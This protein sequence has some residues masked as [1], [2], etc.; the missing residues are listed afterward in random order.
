MVSTGE[1][2]CQHFESKSSN[3]TK[4]SGTPSNVV[5]M[6]YLSPGASFSTRTEDMAEFVS[7]LLLLLLLQFITHWHIFQWNYMQCNLRKILPFF[8]CWRGNA[9]IIIMFML[10]DSASQNWRTGARTAWRHGSTGLLTSS[11]EHQSGAT[12]AAALSRSTTF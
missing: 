1:C 3:C 11:R 10:T 8:L 6:T 7:Y 5:Q 9:K 4:C 12:S 2:W